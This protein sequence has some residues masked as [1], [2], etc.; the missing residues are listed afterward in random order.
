MKNKSYLFAG[1]LIIFGF[2]SYPVSAQTLTQESG[3]APAVTGGLI[4]AM[5]IQAD[6]RIL[7]GGTFTAVNGTSKLRLARLNADGTLDSSL[8]ADALVTGGSYVDSIQALHGGKILIGG[9]FG[10]VGF[11]GDGITRRV[12]RL[13]SDGSLDSTLTT[14]PDVSIGSDSRQTVRQSPNGKIWLCGQNNGRPGI[15]ANL[16]RYNNDGSADS[17][18]VA[19]GV[20]GFMGCMDLKI[21]PDGKTLISGSAF[22]IYGQDRPGGVFRLNADDSLDTGFALAIFPNNLAF[23]RDL[24]PHPDGRIFF[25]YTLVQDGT[26]SF[27]HVN[28]DGS[29]RTTILPRPMGRGVFLPSGKYLFVGDAPDI[30][31]PQPIFYRF[32]SNNVRDLSINT[33]QTGLDAIIRLQ[34]DG[35]ILVAHT[36][37]LKRFS[38]TQIP[39]VPP[40]D[41]DGDG[42]SDISVYR[43]SDQYW[44][45]N[46]SLDNSFFAYRWG[47][48]T[49]KPVAGDYDGD[50]KTDIAQYRD[51]RW[52]ILRSSNWT[53]EERVFG[54]ATDVPFTYDV[55]SNG[56]L[57][58]ILRRTVTPQV[59]WSI[60]RG[61]TGQQ[62]QHGGVPG[63]LP[64]DVPIVGNFHG[65][66]QPEFGYFRNG[67][68][69]VQSRISDDTITNFQWGMAGDIPVPGD[70]DGD[71]TTDFAVFRPSE[72][73]WYIWKS[74]GGFYALHWGVS[75][76]KP[77]PGDYDGDGKTDIAVFRESEGNWYIMNSTAGFSAIHW[78]MPGDQAIPSQHIY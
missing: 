78:G 75:T 65:D 15:P 16:S 9:N 74:F 58:M 27:V 68:W 41:F 62:V 1:I 35:K 46:N 6:G 50:G 53:F 36:E 60:Y 45:I 4:R 24:F 26:P 28:S 61:D 77:V 76:D 12:L 38:E 20:H 23:I 73:N 32:Y 42:R 51:T 72:G 40:F 47:L 25:S 3:F 54:V 57:D 22:S 56:V 7:I 17:T 69:R 55:D 63:E 33:V 29:N 5:D 70:Y 52:Y 64:G 14:Q 49:D 71:F 59:T 37:G 10:A 8:V 43:P 19:S 39:I 13:N 2:V 66:R 30:S 11:P 31:P 18:F 67:A 34:T 21:M 44:Y 48:S